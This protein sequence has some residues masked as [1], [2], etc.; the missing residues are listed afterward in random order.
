MY[1]DLHNAYSLEPIH[2]LP[3]KNKF[4]KETQDTIF[5]K[6]LN[7]LYMLRG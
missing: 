7:N 4:S 2:F 1:K 6:R 5:I 3:K